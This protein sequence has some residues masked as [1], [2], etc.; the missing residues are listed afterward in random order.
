M[1]WAPL[2]I[3]TRIQGDTNPYFCGLTSIDATF[4]WRTDILQLIFFYNTAKK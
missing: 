4:N 3:Y 1:Y 2:E